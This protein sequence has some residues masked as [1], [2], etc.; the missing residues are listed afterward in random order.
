[1]LLGSLTGYLTELEDV[2]LRVHRSH[3]VN[4]AH[5][6]YMEGNFLRIGGRDIPIGA[7]YREEIK[8]RIR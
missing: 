8:E 3:A 4:L 6:A 2:L 7:S 5:L 1:M